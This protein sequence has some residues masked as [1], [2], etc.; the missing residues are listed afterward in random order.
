MKFFVL[1]YTVLTFKPEQSYCS[2]PY[3]A[4]EKVTIIATLCTRAR[5]AFVC[6]STV[7][8]RLPSFLA[9]FHPASFS[10][11]SHRVRGVRLL[12][13]LSVEPPF[14]AMRIAE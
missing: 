13:L 12:T 8:H 10:L 5:V 1:H 9:I 4:V 6:V 3:A 11:L 14:T 2:W 7:L